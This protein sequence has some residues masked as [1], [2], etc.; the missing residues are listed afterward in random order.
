VETLK[1]LGNFIKNTQNNSLPT[2][3]EPPINMVHCN[4]LLHSQVQASTWMGT[5]ELTIYLS[6]QY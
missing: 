4:I 6:K 1:Q 2:Q 5:S 3:N